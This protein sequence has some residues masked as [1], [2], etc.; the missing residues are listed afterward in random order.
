MTFQIPLGYYI[1]LCHGGSNSVQILQGIFI[2]Y[3]RWDAWH[4]AAAFMDDVNVRRATYSVRTNS[5]GWY[6]STTFADPCTVHSCSLSPCL[7]TTTL[8]GCSTL[9]GHS[10]EHWD[11]SVHLGH[12]ND[13][14]QVLQCVKKAGGTYSGWKWMSDPRSCS[15]GPPLHLWR[16]YQKIGRSRRLWIGWLQYSHRGFWFP[17][18]MW[19]CTNL[20]SRDFAS[21]QGPW[22]ILTKKEMDFSGPR[23]RAF[24]GGLEAGDHYSPMPLPIDYHSNRLFIL[25]VDSSWF[26]WVSFSIAWADTSAIQAN[27]S[28]ITWMRENPTTL[29]QK[30]NS[31]PFGVPSKHI[32]L[33]SSVEWWNQ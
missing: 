9:W 1:P 33:A 19:H 28:S 27:F 14:N 32:A 22:F 6:I 17:G 29:R 21:M 31:W 13:I 26:P 25:A 16:N 18:S 11:P 10:G 30:S 24:Y 4:M 23:Q 5:T 7:Q 12:L 2:Y 3:T 15:C 8:A 20:G